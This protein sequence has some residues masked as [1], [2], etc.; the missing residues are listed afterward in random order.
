MKKVLSSENLLIFF[1][2]NFLQRNAFMNGDKLITI[3]SD[4]ASTGSCKTNT[5]SPLTLHIS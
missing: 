1:I 2:F 5:P 3:I 4:A